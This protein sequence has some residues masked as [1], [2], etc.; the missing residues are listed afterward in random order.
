MENTPEPKT[1]N[2]Q[3]LITMAHN[4]HVPM[5]EDTIASMVGETGQVDS[6]KAKAFEEY[7]KTTAS[8]LYP[9]LAKQI[10]GGIPTAYLIEPY[11]Q[12]AKQMLGGNVELDFQTDPKA[13]AALHG[14]FDPETGRPAPM[15]LSQWKEHITSHSGFEW[16]KTPQ[17]HEHVQSVLDAIGTSMGV[18]QEGK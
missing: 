2:A 10:Q 6:S 3:E 13:V 16:D 15:S 11:R 7:L 17:A 1:V 12:V 4:Y 5:H 14:G 9:T 18:T 8:G